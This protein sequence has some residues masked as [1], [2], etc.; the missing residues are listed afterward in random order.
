[1]PFHKSVAGSP[2]RSSK[3]HSAGRSH[4]ARSIILNQRDNF[5]D[6]FKQEQ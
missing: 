5:K 6:L 2:D 4:K 3:N 1:M